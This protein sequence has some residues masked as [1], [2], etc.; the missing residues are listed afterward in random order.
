MFHFE[1]KVVGML[2]EPR[3]SVCECGNMNRGV[4]KN[5]VI[6]PED[7]WTLVGWKNKYM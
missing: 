4:E 3:L 2:Y 7:L 5:H 1:N 6:F